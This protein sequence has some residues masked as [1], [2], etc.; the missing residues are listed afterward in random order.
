LP[1]TPPCPLIA[2]VPD[3]IPYVL[4]YINRWPPLIVAAY[5]RR[6]NL[7]KRF[8]KAMM[9]FSNCIK[10]DLVKYLDV[11]AE[12]ISVT[13]LAV[14]PRLSGAGE[15]GSKGGGDYILYVGDYEY[16][17]NIES[18]IQAYAR[19]PRRLQTENG[20]IIVCDGD[21]PIMTR[22]N[23]LVDRVNA[24]GEVKLLSFTDP[25]SP[26]TDSKLAFL[27]KNASLFVFPSLYEGF[28]L[29]AL[30][31]MSLGVPVA[32]SNVSSIAEVIGD[33]AVLF[34]P[35]NVEDIAQKIRLVLSDSKL[36][37]KLVTAGRS[38]VNQFSWSKCASETSEVYKSCIGKE[39]L[40]ASR[41]IAYLSPLNPQAS[42]ISD[43]S[44]ELLKYL[45]DFFE[46]DVY[47]DGFEPSNRQI[48][49]TF[50]IRDISELQEHI[51][52]YGTCVYNMS[53]NPEYHMSIY[54][55]MQ[56]YPGITILHE[57]SCHPA[58]FYEYLVQSRNELA[59]LEE[60][61]LNFGE[62]GVVEARRVIREGSPNLWDYPLNKKAVLFSK[63]VIMHVPAIAEGLQKETG[64]PVLGLPMGVEAKDRNAHELRERKRMLRSRHGISQNAFV[65]ATVGYLS[66]LRR[67]D[68]CIRA[69]SRLRK[70]GIDMKFLVAGT[71]LDEGL[72]EELVSLAQSLGVKSNLI[73]VEFG[74]DLALCEEYILLSDVFINLRYPSPGAPSSVILRALSFAKPVIASNIPDFAHFPNGCAWKV[75]PDKT[76]QDLLFRYL[77]KLGNDRGLREKMGE[78]AL[79]FAD[80]CDWSIVSKTMAQFISQ[81]QRAP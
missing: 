58:F 80:Q 63:G 11:P 1:K 70:E 54:R 19:L 79:A 28:G 17:K 20:L 49:D 31:A 42:G 14:D 56:R 34:D 5:F 65:V 43:Y 35:R 27:Y 74:K 47:V 3:L 69:I 75:D 64:V 7:V 21:P 10:D 62:R 38:R 50:T 61:A 48:R 77:L 18:L 51:D 72:K 16:R 8:A 9:T 60:L 22:L 30:E 37:A 2:T 33:A 53:N 4:G 46:I 41:K 6:L 57:Y 78:N 39:Q 24:K 71:F 15:S 73:L 52:E 13:N 81:Y 68:V 76:E 55:E 32:T 36:R 40:S 12:R 25:D 44:E 29:P 66:R 67:L 23:D 59:Y 45:Q 26:M